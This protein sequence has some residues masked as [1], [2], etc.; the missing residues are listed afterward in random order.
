M[1]YIQ[2]TF[3]NIISLAL[4]GVGLFIFGA[5]LQEPVANGVESISIP[6]LSGIASTVK[7]L[8]F[9]PGWGTV[10][11]LALVGIV[12]LTFKLKI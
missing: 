7:F 11:T 6:V 10:I 2:D 1:A 12:T 9:T 3:S 4:I 8:I 5:L